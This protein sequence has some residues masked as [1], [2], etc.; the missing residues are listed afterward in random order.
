LKPWEILLDIVIAVVVMFLF[1]VIY[2]SQKSDSVIQALVEQET[3]SFVDEVR[4]KGYF[5]EDMYNKYLHNVSKMGVKPKIEIEQTCSTL[6]P[7]YRFRT[8]DEIIHENDNAYGGTNQ[9]HY[10]P[11]TSTVPTVYDPINNGGLNT[12]TNE[13]VL[14]NAV[15]TPASPTHT[16]TD[17]CYAGHRHNEN[18]VMAGDT[19]VSVYISYAKTKRSSYD[20]AYDTHYYIH[21]ANCNSVIAQY[22]IGSSKY[23]YTSVINEYLDFVYT[24]YKNGS[25]ES[26][27][28]RSKHFFDNNGMFLT[29]EEMTEIKTLRTMA[30]NINTILYSEM[31]SK[32]RHSG[33]YYSY[34]ESNGNIYIRTYPFKW[35]AGDFRSIDENF[36]YQYHKY[37]GCVFCGVYGENYSCGKV[38]DE[39]PVCNQKIVSITP[40]HPT[41]VVYV[42]E[43][44]I[45]TAIATYLDG[46][47]RTIVCSTSFST[48]DVGQSQTA[49]LTY[50][51]TIAGKSYSISTTITISVIPRVKTCTNGHTYNLNNDSSDP[52]CPYCRAWLQ[53]LRVIHPETGNITIY[54]GTT[55][56]DNGVMVLATYMDGHTEILTS[57]FINNLDI[58]YVGNQTVTITYKGKYTYLYVT[59]RRNLMKCSECGNYYELYPDDTDPGCPYCE[60]KMPVFTGHV[61]KYDSK[62]YHNEIMQKVIDEGIYYFSDDDYISINING[63]DSGWVN[64]LLRLF[65]KSSSVNKIRYNYG[66]YVRGDGDPRS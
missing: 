51:Y 49:T 29:P 15:N 42:G 32:G 62:T 11:V 22:S 28:Y 5:S 66:G 30:S 19:N 59:T 24:S 2:F 1:P 34:E 53:D 41:Q 40:T 7:E 20:T 47:T 14:A 21:C 58:S 56:E 33:E 44:L 63:E 61:L 36:N 27:T 25:P 39:N 16:H 48:T 38:Q 57:G 9:Y 52:G 45:T 31:E 6:E 10:F 50:N 46:S 18:C 65:S 17:E 43:P 23:G 54:R 37:L 3:K 60:A 13:S 8:L 26:T 55:L 12:E 4:E 35:T 64:M